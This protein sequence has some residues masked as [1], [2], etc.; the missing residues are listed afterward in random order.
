MEVQEKNLGEKEINVV[1]DS[2][3]TA[4]KEQQELRDLNSSPTSLCHLREVC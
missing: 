3:S 1:L 2:D 4:N